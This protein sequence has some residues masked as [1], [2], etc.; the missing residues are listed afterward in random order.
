[1]NT[2][3]RFSTRLQKFAATAAVVGA[4][5]P[6]SA[7]ALALDTT[8]LQ[9]NSV[10]ALSE[11]AFDLMA[12]A[13]TSMTFAGNASLGSGTKASD[14]S[15]IPTFNLPVTKVDVS[16]G[17]PLFGGQLITPNSGNATGSALLISRGSNTVTL[18]NFV[19]DYDSSLVMA[20]ITAN[21][22]TTKN[23][24]LYSF[25]ATKLD[26]G[27]AGLALNMHQQ[28]SN[29]TFTS[30]AAASFSSGLKLPGSF[31][32]LISTLDFG[33]ITIDINTGLRHAISDKPFVA[34]SVPEA[35]SMAAMVLGL[36]GIAA[37]SRRKAA[38]G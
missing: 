26:V 13:K 36:V 25:N 28:L 33:T 1:M 22:K 20:D 10:F 35:P 4:M 11:N 9:A 15:L 34:S 16:L 24:S 23:T 7:S 5:A 30:S 38:Q 6:L 19:I 31:Q 21:G 8:F 29:L 18:A 3:Y 12:A 2:L 17:L 14:G 37:V 27:L 32:T